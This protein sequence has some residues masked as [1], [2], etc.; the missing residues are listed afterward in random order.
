MDKQAGTTLAEGLQRLQTDHQSGSQE[1]TSFALT[2]FRDVVVQSRTGDGV[3]DDQWWTGVRM[4]AWHLGKN[5]RE[6]MGTSVMN[7]LISVLEDIDEFRRQQLANEAKWKRILGAIDYHLQD[8]KSRTKKPR[9][10]S[11]TIC[12]RICQTSREQTTELSS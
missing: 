7:A 2:V 10:P 6:S 4:A 11:P 5:G 12:V 3:L 8:R 9:R 1:L